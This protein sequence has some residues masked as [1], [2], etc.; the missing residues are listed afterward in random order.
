MLI[1]YFQ[2]N[3]IQMLRYAIV[4][5][6]GAL[7]DLGVLYIL[8]EFFDIYYL[9]STTTAFVVSALLN[10]YFNRRWTFGSTGNAKKQLLIFAFVSSSGLLINA[11]AM[12]GLVEGLHIYYMLAKIFS[13]AVVTIWNFLWNKYLTFRV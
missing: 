3:K 10:F 7:V 11:G 12:Y 6:T 2:D 4:G 13:I 9:Y 1:K 8:T 5:G